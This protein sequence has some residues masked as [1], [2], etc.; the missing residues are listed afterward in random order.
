ML[1]DLLLSVDQ[2]LLTAA[3][4]DVATKWSPVLHIQPNLPQN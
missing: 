2:S 3:F 4:P 1:P